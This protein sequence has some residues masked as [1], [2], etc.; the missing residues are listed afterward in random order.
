MY[1][2]YIQRYDNVDMRVPYV[3]L[4]QNYY[5]MKRAIK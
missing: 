4:Q 1:G 3:F 5:C 2:I